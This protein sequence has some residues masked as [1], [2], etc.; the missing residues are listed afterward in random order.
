LKDKSSSGGRGHGVIGPS[1]G[2]PNHFVQEQI[3]GC[4]LFGKIHFDL[5][6]PGMGAVSL[7]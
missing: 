5:A 4:V 3:I 2:S 7:L 6:A 1:D